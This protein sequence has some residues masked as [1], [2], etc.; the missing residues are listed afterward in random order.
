MK[1][2]LDN[3]PA[4]LQ[5]DSAVLERCL[6]AMDQALPIKQVLLFGSH[7]RGD[8]RKDSDVDLCLVAENA[9][10]QLKASRIF[11]NAIWELR[12]CPAFTLLPITPQR[13]REKRESGDHFFRTVLKESVVLANEN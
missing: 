12:D 1:L 2:H 6:I 11:R 5:K 9:G 8:A 10:A 4:S 7:A 3:L 13:L